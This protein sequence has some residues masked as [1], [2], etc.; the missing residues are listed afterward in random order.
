V[1]DDPHLS[2]IPDDRDYDEDRWIA[3]GRVGP[4]ILVVV[5]TERNG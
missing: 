3:G 2:V 4:I 5:F 1:F